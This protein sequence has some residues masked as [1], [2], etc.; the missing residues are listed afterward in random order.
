MQ[1][2]NCQSGALLARRLIKKLSKE[3]G[4]KNEALIWGLKADSSLREEFKQLLPNSIDGTH[5]RTVMVLNEQ[6]QLDGNVSPTLKVISENTLVYIPHADTWNQDV[7][8]RVCFQASQK[9][10]KALIG[11][12]APSALSLGI[13]QFL[14]TQEISEKCELN[15]WAVNMGIPLRD[16]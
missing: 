1:Q 11:F 13:L 9:S 16:I 4:S 14:V 15:D 2:N 6:V 7:L 8:L 5:V 12:S 3:I 10:S